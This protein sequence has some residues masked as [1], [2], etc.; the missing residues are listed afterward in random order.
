MGFGTHRV[1][2]P[3]KFDT[4][5]EHTDRSACGFF[6]AMYEKCQPREHMVPVPHCHQVIQIGRFVA[7]KL[8]G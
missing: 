4:F 5:A 3:E 7:L 1:L 8:D 6:D 2:L